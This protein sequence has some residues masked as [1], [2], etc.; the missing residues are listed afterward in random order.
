[1]RIHGA[2][3]LVAPGLC[4][5][6]VA[7]CIIPDED[8]DVQPFRSNPGAVRLVHWIPLV[9]AAHQ[10]CIEVDPRLRG[11]PLPSDE[12][13]PGLVDDRD[14]PLCSCPGQ[15]DANAL[16]FFDILV[17]DADVDDE[18]RPR[19]RILGVFLLDPP[20]DPLAVTAEHVAY[21][22]LL[23]PNTPATLPPG[24]T[25][26]AQAIGRE[27]PLVRKW[28]IGFDVPVD[29][30]NPDDR[31]PLS[32]GLHE[33][34]LVVTD[35]P[36]YRRV[37]LELDEGPNGEPIERPIET[38]DGYEREDEDPLIGVPD[39]PGGASYDQATWIFR[40]RDAAEFEQCACVDRE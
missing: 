21:T 12:E 22:S 25:L 3:R 8:I 14:R 28:T 19:D 32:P 2:C 38:A 9:D 35:R 29:L 30:C 27:A 10:A 36:W 34:R 23:S 1:M 39:L 15:R 4:L 31:P 40:C 33:L 5:L 24:G 20:R 6:G 13:E 17:E 16:N 26:Y 11:C 18:G 7:A 37:A